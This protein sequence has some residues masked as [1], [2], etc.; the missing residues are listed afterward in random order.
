MWFGWLTNIIQEP[1]LNMSQKR[2]GSV[3]NKQLLKNQFLNMS[4]GRTGLQKYAAWSERTRS[5]IVDW[6]RL[7]I[8][9]KVDSKCYRA[10]DNLI[11]TATRLDKTKVPWLKKRST[12]VWLDLC[13]SILDI[14]FS[15]GLC[16]RFNL[17]QRILMW[18]LGRGY[19]GML[20]YIG[21]DPL[22]PIRRTFWANRICKC[23]LC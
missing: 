19:L 4:T 7:L 14:V 12:G 3:Y 16:A 11:A 8:R 17:V 1:F 13:Y 9:C 15:V 6:R 18:K 22:A 20:R 5:F 10:I 21:P 2:T 23:C